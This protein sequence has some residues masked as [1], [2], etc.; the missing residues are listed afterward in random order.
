MNLNTQGKSSFVRAITAVLLGGLW[1]ASTATCH[2]VVLY[3]CPGVGSGGDASDR[4]FYMTNF[5]GVT[6]DS[7]TLKFV[8]AIAGTYQVSLTVHSNAYNGPILGTST[9]TVV[10]NAYP[11]ASTSA[12]FPFAA[13]PMPKGGTVCFSLA[14]VSGPAS[15]M[16]YD[17]GGGCREVIETEGTT[18]PL[19]TFRGLGVDLTITGS[20]NYL[21]S[22]GTGV[23][24]DW[25]YRGF[26]MTN[27]PGASLDSATLQYKGSVAGTYQVSLTVR[28]GTF[29][30]P[31][32]GT[33]AI[34]VTVNSI[35][36]PPVDAT[37]PFGNIPIPGGET[38]CF[39]QNVVSGPYPYVFYNVA[40]GCPGVIET[41]DTTPPLSTFR[42]SGVNLKLTGAP[43]VQLNIARSGSTVKVFWQNVAGWNL[44]QTP[45][46][47]PP[48]GWSPSSGITTSSGTNFLNLIP[49]PAP[50]KMFFRLKYP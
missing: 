34:T 48:A 2:A 24:Y 44:E 43:Y 32:L 12:T 31:V 19:S 39:I 29:D 6:M 7:A 49:P 17:V 26:Y 22:C 27:F 21:Y 15:Y 36:D 40:G 35:S 16:Y 18:P 3:S 25:N 47:Y 38:V 33:S 10:L 5:P 50:G 9:I 11:G 13:I 37:F 41:E 1:L 45:S 20:S 46:L 4:G 23:A 30:G 8:G 42:N 28:N 14:V